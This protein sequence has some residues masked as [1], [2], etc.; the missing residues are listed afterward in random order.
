VSVPV[1][2]S[3]WP[4]N[5][6]ALTVGINGMSGRCVGQGAWQAVAPG[7]ATF[8]VPVKR[9]KVLEMGQKVNEMHPTIKLKWFIIKYLL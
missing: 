3:C 2:K 7:C 1:V 5:C 8:S 9:L 4:A 6:C